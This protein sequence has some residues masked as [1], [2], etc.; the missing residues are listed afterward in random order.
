MSLYGH[1]GR[2]TRCVRAL[3]MEGQDGHGTTH[4]G[5]GV[6]VRCALMSS[7]TREVGFCLCS[8]LYQKRIRNCVPHFLRGKLYVYPIICV[9][10]IKKTSS[11]FACGFK[12][13]V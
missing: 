9:S 3:W 12:R 13:I 4:V 10:D 7:T 8:F 2:R 1:V 11:P 6:K 5:P